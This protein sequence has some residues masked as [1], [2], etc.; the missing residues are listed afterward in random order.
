MKYMGKILS[1]S[2]DF[3]VE[4]KYTTIS[5]ESVFILI[6]GEFYG[7]WNFCSVGR[8]GNCVTTYGYGGTG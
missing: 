6:W 1:H 8:S 7:D 5:I 3:L 2:I 4:W